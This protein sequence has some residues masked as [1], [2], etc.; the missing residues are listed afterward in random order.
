MRATEKRE[1]LRAILAGPKCVSPVTVFDALSARVA[2]SVGCEV[3]VLSG[4]IGAN[5]KPIA[6]GVRI[7]VRWINDRGGVNGHPLNLVQGDSG[8]DPL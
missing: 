4:P 7:W 8:G 5:M 3:G 1:R 6:D 2:Q